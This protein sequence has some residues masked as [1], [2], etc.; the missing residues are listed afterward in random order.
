[1]L[2]GVPNPTLEIAYV[3]LDPQAIVTQLPVVGNVTCTGLDLFIVSFFPNCPATLLPHTHN[4]SSC[5][6]AAE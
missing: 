4:V 2:Y 3:V 6:I 1:M 5:L